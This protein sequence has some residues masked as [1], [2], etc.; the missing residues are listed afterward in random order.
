MATNERQIDVAIIG[1]SGHASAELIKILASHPHARITA[2]VTGNKHCAGTSIAQLHPDLAG[3]IDRKCELLQPN[4]IAERCDVAIA[5]TPTEESLRYVPEIIGAGKKCIDLS[6]AYRLHD[7]ATFREHYSLEH[8]DP[9][10]LGHAVYGLP[11]LFREKIRM[12]MLIANPGCY[13]TASAI[14]IAPALKRGLV[15]T[16]QPIIIRAI[17]GYSGAGVKYQP[18]SGVRPYKIARH[19]HTPEIAQVCMDYLLDCHGEARDMQVSFA[20]RIND[21]S[22]RGIDADSSM[23]LSGPFDED[24]IRAAYEAF[25]ASEPF[26]DVL[27]TEPDVKNVVGTNGAHVAVWKEGNLLH[28]I[29]TIDNLRKGAAS[30]AIQNLN[31]LCGF[32]ETAGLL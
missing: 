5:A 22:A 13:P 9:A 2:L 10:N 31:L 16:R 28:V 8:T 19:Q 26:I 18:T 20:P 14:G 1:T 7:S 11:E 25:Y 32:E 12:A 30:Q 15:D 17:S 24:D 4:E 3:C 23:I 29:S 21:D 27:R 6:G